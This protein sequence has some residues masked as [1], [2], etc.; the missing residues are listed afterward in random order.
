MRITKILHHNLPHLANLLSSKLDESQQDLFFQDLLILQYRSL[1]LSQLCDQKEQYTKKELLGEFSSK[2]TWQKSKIWNNENLSLL[3]KTI[4]LPTLPLSE[5]FPQSLPPNYANFTQEFH[6]AHERILADNLVLDSKGSWQ[7]QSSMQNARK[8]TGSFY[9]PLKLV[10]TII[11]QLL[12]TVDLR[13]KNLPPPEQESYL[14]S[15]RFC[16]PSCGTGNFLGYLRDTLGERLFQIR[17]QKTPLE[18]CLRDILENCIYGADINWLS[19]ELCRLGLWWKNQ[20]SKLSDNFS[21]G[22]ALLGWIDP[23][24]SFY[25]KKSFPKI[26]QAGG[27]DF[28]LGNP[29]YVD[30]ETMKKQSLQLRKQYHKGFQS[31][32]GN[33]DLY[34]PFSELGLRLLKP[35]GIVALLTPKNIIGSDYAKAIQKIWLTHQLL[36]IQDFSNQDW[37][38]DA[39]ISVTVVACQNTAVD[40]SKEMLFLRYLPQRIDEIKT[41]IATLQ[42]LPAGY[43]S[44]PLHAENPEQINWLSLPQLAS[45]ATCSDGASTKEAY[46]IR[47]LL[48]EGKPKDRDDPQKIKLLNTGTIDPFERLWGKKLCRYLGF[49]GLH[50]TIDS[51][52]LKE[53]HPKRWNQA[54][55]KKLIVAGLSAQIEAV[56]APPSYLCGKTTTQIIPKDPT[57]ICPDALVCY[58]NSKPIFSFYKAIF[59]MRGF[60]SRSFLIGP[61]QIEQLPIPPVEYFT[62]W[63]ASQKISSK[64]QLSYWGKHPEQ[65]NQ[66]QLSSFILDLLRSN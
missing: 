12:E 31:T 45:I 36:W 35:N 53:S 33:W 15:L 28:I 13:L 30:S 24:H 60:S 59:A 8:Q 52:K 50:P 4:P 32:K 34:I 17:E 54:M 43:I 61:R 1:L 65:L 5:L 40:S 49:R 51:Q 63:S 6:Q 26:F 10:K 46:E 55:Q 27:F 20:D 11:D 42:K 18:T 19:V 41:K 66:D 21:V 57:S 14:L 25:W 22:D 48:Y 9:T 29:P 62:S 44:F 47:E 64:N 7:L 39:K 23:T 58:L 37:F 56:L 2:K 3:G 16:D 38:E